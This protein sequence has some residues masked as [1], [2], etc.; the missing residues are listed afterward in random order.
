MTKEV[1]AEMNTWAR[2]GPVVVE[3]DGTAEGLRIVDYACL[4]ALRSEAEL[5]LVAPYQAHGSFS[6]TDPERRPQAPA[7]LAGDALRAA[8]AH[9]RHRYGY[10]LTVTAV[11]EEGARS[12]V[13][14]H[15]ARHARMLVVART[16]ARGPHRLVAA[17]ANLYLAGRTGCPLVVVPLSWK[18]SAA[19]RRVAVGI[20]GSP[21][22]GEA[23]E[24]A[25]RE[26]ADRGGDLVV[27]HAGRQPDRGPNDGG[28]NDGRVEESWVT[29][30]DRVVADA[31]G[32]W[33][34]EF[35][36]V[37]VTRYLSSRPAAAALVHESQTAGL[38][39]VGA[40]P[41][42]LPVDPVARRAVAAMTGP[43]AVVAH[44]S[45]ATERVQLR[46]QRTA[47]RAALVV[48]AY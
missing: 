12:R 35:G 33:S 34:G 42:L 30:A 47:R 11:A 9:L 43:V 36:E 7:E 17:Q 15:A 13:L 23:L 46:D 24:F 4:A 44:H 16:R 41:G 19:D 2:T 14:P 22:S 1:E 21:L 27:V 31:L 3:V 29:G 38:V 40:H 10:G 45:T 48:P 28:P 25:F 37:K 5:V 26:A 8:V 39:V 6:S 20:D 18:P 32:A